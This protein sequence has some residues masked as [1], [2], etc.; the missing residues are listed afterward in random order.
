MSERK[1]ATVLLAI[2]AIAALG[3]SGYLFIKNEIIAAPGTTT[4]NSGLI[5]VGLWDNL[6][7]NTEYDPYNIDSSWLIEFADN[8]FNDSNHIEMSNNNTSFKLLKEGF[9][10]ITLLL[11][12]A[13]LD[14][15]EVYWAYLRRNGIFDHCLARVAISANPS[16]PYHQV[17]SSAYVKSTGLDNFSINCYSTG[18]DLFRIGTSAS[19]IQFSI[20]YS[21]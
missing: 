1:G 6:E 20:E 4:P 8:Q 13:D 21:Q 18:F 15:G 11:M 17:E 12:L 5:L 7:K 10:K 16:S 3:F 9:Y 19:F 2:I 14:P